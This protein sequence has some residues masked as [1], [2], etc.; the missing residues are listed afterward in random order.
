MAPDPVDEVR[1]SVTRTDPRR[2]LAQD[3]LAGP[4]LGDGRAGALDAMRARDPRARLEAAAHQLHGAPEA[5]QAPV[6]PAPDEPKPPVR[7]L[8]L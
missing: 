3:T 5:V 1:A 7:R 4:L 8:S 6:A 2:V